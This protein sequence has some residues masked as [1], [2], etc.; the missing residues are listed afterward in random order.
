MAKLDDVKRTSLLDTV[1]GDGIVD[2]FE[3]DI[4]SLP[5]SILP[6]IVTGFTRMERWAFGG[7]AM[8]ALLDIVVGVPL[9]VHYSSQS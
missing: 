7:V 6:G 4:V 8:L 3:D 9:Y 5:S 1:G 2:D